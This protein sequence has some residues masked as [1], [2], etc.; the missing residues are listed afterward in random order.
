LFR[1]LTEKFFLARFLKKSVF[2]S[3]FKTDPADPPLWCL[4]SSK[5]K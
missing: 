5:P 4:V 1:K 3:G 2:R